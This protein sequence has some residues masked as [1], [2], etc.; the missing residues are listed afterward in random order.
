MNVFSSPILLPDAQSILEPSMPRLVEAMVESWR[1][2]REDYRAQH[3]VLDETTRA[4]IV[5]RN[6]YWNV[7][8]KVG[9][10]D[11]V[12]FGD[13]NHQRFVV[14]KDTLIMR[15]KFLGRQLE[16]HNYPTPRAQ[17][18]ERQTSLPDFPRVARLNFGYRLDSTG[19]RIKDA[20]VTLPNGIKDVVND[21][22]WQIWGSPLDRDT[23]GIQ[24]R[25][26]PKLGESAAVYAWEDYSTHYGT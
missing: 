21:W 16:A 3:V 1:V 7:A 15:F 25:F 20:F 23:F 13:D 6:W 17:D 5:N 22:V 26:P 9:E 2:W 10:A 4:M 11:G 24:L 14:V 12:R 8:Q 19:T 18:W